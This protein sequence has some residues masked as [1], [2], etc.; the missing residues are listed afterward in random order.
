MVAKTKITIDISDAKISADSGH[1]L[2][3]YSLGSCIGVCLYDPNNHIGGM[4]H[5]LLP[6]SGMNPEQAREN[7]FK[8]CDTG[9]STLLDKL[10]SMGVNKKRLIVKVAGGAKVLKS[11]D[12]FD[13][14]KRNYIAIRKFLWKNGMLINAEDVGGSIPRTLM[15]SIA[16]GSVAIKSKGQKKIL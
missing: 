1:E 14:G 4:L 13:I 9:M 10:V 3:T 7:P 16:D 6:S 12:G 2:V 15:L 8:F 5:Y 11:V